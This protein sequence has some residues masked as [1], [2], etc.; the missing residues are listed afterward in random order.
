MGYIASEYLADGLVTTKMDVFAYGVVLLELVS[1]ARP[2]VTATASRCGPTRK[3]DVSAGQCRERG[4]RREGVPAP[5]SAR[6]PSMVDV[7]YTLSK[8]DEHFADYSGVSSTAA[9]G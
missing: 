2:S 8:A 1:G 6:R 5:G 4:E 3:T 9:A 7:A